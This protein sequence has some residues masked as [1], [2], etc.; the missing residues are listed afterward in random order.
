LAKQ[1][2]KSISILDRDLTFEGILSS[3]G[4][5]IIRG[6]FEGSL[7]GERIVISRS[8]AVR[9]DTKAERV[10][11]AGSFDGPLEVAG[12]LVIRSTGQCSGTLVCKTLAVEA[13]GVLNADVRCEP[14][15]AASVSQKP[16]A[17]SGSEKGS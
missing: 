15:S 10:T 7:S 12:E 6:T 8:G 11:V 16:D 4:T 3:R 2:S 14:E 13:G 9:G 17:Q 5:L 1:K